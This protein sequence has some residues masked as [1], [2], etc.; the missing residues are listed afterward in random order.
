MMNVISNPWQALRSLTAAR[1]ALGRTMPPSFQR[2]L[3]QLT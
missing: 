2:A 1:I 3:A